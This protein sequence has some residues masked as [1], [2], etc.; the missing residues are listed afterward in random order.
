M[1]PLPDAVQAVQHLI[2]HREGASLH[3]LDVALVTLLRRV[4]HLPNEIRWPEDFE[5]PSRAAEFSGQI[6]EVWPELGV[7]DNRTGNEWHPGTDEIGDAIDDLT[8]IAVDFER[9]LQLLPTDVPGA[10]SYLRFAAV[11]HWGEHVQGLVR[12]L[13]FQQTRPPSAEQLHELLEAALPRGVVDRVGAARL[14][15]F[16][17]RVPPL[18]L[19]RVDEQWRQAFRVNWYD[20]TGPAGWHRAGSG[21]QWRSN[22]PVWLREH[23]DDLLVA[24]GVVAALA[25]SSDGYAREAAVRLLARIEHPLTTAVLLVRATDWVEP[26]RTAALRALHTRLSEQYAPHWARYAALIDRLE[27]LERGDADLVGKAR[28]LLSTPAGLQAIWDVLPRADRETRLS[29]LRV[30]EEL[31]EPLRVTWLGVFAG[32]SHALVRRR[33]ADLAPVDQL[34]GLIADLD[35]GVREVVL[36]RLVDSVPA[37][38]VPPFLLTALLD[39]RTGVRALAQF[40]AL[41]RGV[42]LGAA[43]LD[44]NES[45][46]SRAALRGWTAGVRELGLVDAKSRLEALLQHPNAR[47]RVEVLRALGALAPHRHVGLLENGLLGSGAET[48]VASA[49]LRAANLLTTER[50]KALWSRTVTDRQRRRLV[51]L[52][53]DLPRFDAAT[54]LLEWHGEASAEVQAGLEERLTALLE[55]YGVRYYV[56]PNES[57]K[58]RLQQAAETGRLSERLLRLMRDLLS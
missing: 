53:A 54:L 26:V 52:A 2:L 29:L 17:D 7:Y 41:R 18:L 44:M 22:L 28:A 12:H 39:P 24:P 45:T 35:A 38:E 9:V 37:N 11:T 30:V 49:A 13:R 58:A 1:Q 21:W 19:P 46:L 31:P 15:A 16:L 55:G 47:V 6:G 32:D 34:Y 51:R 48:R 56:R 5:G 57:Q 8:D 50:L 3:D 10:L 43:Y 36:R 23:P 14:L 4:L 33:V 25:S 42:D 40:E 27:Q 20:A